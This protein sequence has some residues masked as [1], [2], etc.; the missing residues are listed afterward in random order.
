MTAQHTPGPWECVHNSWEVSTVYSHG[1]HGVIAECPIDSGVCEETQYHLEAVKDA[2]AEFIV[3]ACN[4]H[5]ELLEALKE[6]VAS[7]D[8]RWEGSTTR[9]RENAISPRTEDALEAARTLIA[10]ARKP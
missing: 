3:R 10:K 5:Y 7:I 9:Q 6:L 8:R 2:N 4:S 1:G